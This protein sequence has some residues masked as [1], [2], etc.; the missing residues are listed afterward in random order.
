MNSCQDSREVYFRNKINNLMGKKNV[1]KCL[2]YE[3]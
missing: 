1:I 3:K 2:Q